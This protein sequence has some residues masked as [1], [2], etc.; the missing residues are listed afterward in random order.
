MNRLNL[1]K[2][3]TESVERLSLT[4]PNSVALRSVMEQ[5]RYLIEVETGISKDTSKLGQI[6][7]GVLAA[8]EVEDM[9]A[10]VAEE[11]YVVSAEV[12]KMKAV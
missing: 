8:K 7:I 2:A 3:A 6:N 11:L 12:K 1:F 10:G 9:D 5:L 4:Y